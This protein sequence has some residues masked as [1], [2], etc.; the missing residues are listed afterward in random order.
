MLISHDRED[1]FP[2]VKYMTCCRIQPGSSPTWL[3]STT[4]FCHMFSHHFYFHSLLNLM[5]SNMSGAWVNTIAVRKTPLF[6]ITCMFPQILQNKYSF[7]ISDQFTGWISALLFLQTP[8][9]SLLPRDHERLITA[10]RRS[11]RGSGMR[12]NSI[13]TLLVLWLEYTPLRSNMCSSKE[14]S[15]SLNIKWKE[16]HGKTS[17]GCT[18][19]Y[20][21]TSISTIAVHELGDMK[22]CV[23][24]IIYLLYYWYPT[25]QRPDFFCWWI[26]LTMCQIWVM[27]TIRLRDLG[28][29]KHLWHVLRNYS[30]HMS[31]FSECTENWYKFMITKQLRRMLLSFLQ[32]LCSNVCYSVLEERIVWFMDWGFWLGQAEHR[33]PSLNRHGNHVFT[34]H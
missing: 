10:H 31:G 18:S 14:K 5:G 23:C 13:F 1:Q 8:E 28:T 4:G 29:N 27:S 7:L 34:G 32:L 21:D 22:H 11:E 19:G 20:I 3:G 24:T 33:C 26:G 2:V 17:R 12:V 30:W 6:L 9:I 16:N 15:L 25:A